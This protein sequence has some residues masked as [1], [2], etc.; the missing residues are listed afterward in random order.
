VGFVR[1]PELFMKPG[2][3]VT[4]EIES[5]GTLTNPVEAE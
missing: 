5:L 4:V 1:D 2:D 3:A